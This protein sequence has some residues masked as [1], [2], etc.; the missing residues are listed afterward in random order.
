MK[1]TNA[2][3]PAYG[4]ANHTCVVLDLEI[5]GVKDTLPFC[6]TPND[7]M[8]YGRELFTRATS[9]EFGTVADYIAPAPIVPNLVS[10]AQGGIALIQAGLMDA[11]QVVV[12]DPETPAEHKWAWERA[13]VWTR[14]SPALNFLADKAGIS[15]QQMD[16][17]FIAAALIQA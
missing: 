11:V 5:E 4:N 7:V 3:N 17:L 12:N 8:E 2:K 14:N 6:A 13:Q 16:G 10:A 1:I 15:Q 9:G